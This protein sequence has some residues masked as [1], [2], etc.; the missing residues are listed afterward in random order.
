ML[1]FASTSSLIIKN[2]LHMYVINRFFI[3]SFVEILFKSSY[4]APFLNKTL[5]IKINPDLTNGL[6][7]IHPICLYTSIAL[8][9]W[10]YMTFSFV[11]FKSLFINTINY[12]YYDFTYKLFWLSLLLITSIF[13]GC[14]WAQ[15]ELSW[16][17]WWG[18]D[19]VEIVSLNY[20]TISV[21]LIHLG[22]KHY[23]IHLFTDFILKVLFF[24]AIV[25]FSYLDSIHN[26]ASLDIF[27]QNFYQL[28]FFYLIIF[29]SIIKAKT[30]TKIKYMTL[31]TFNT[32][33][34]LFV[35][36]NIFLYLYVMVEFIYIFYKN[37]GL[38]MY[39]IKNKYI[40]YLI[41]VIFGCIN[42]NQTK[43][44]ILNIFSIP[45]WE[46]SWVKFIMNVQ[47]RLNVYI[48]HTS[49]FILVYILQFNTLLYYDFFSTYDTTYD[50]IVNTICDSCY[51]Y[52][53]N[54]Q[55]LNFNKKLD[56]LFNERFILDK[57]ALVL[58]NNQQHVH[59]MSNLNRQPNTLLLNIAGF[60]SILV[61]LLMC[62]MKAALNKKKY[63]F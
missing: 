35:V 20:L 8:I 51:M 36:L 47:Y 7:L 14:W 24:T 1:F 42:Q 63:L 15:L 25:K 60:F 30:F 59:E 29:Y 62:I 55:L 22:S 57:N 28:A 31:N 38:N 53:D 50:T 40:F 11:K 5:E 17:G 37:T 41:L 23:L 4:S 48:L 19:F 13:L 6:L 10:I 33:L 9:L 2:G 45:F 32:L 39:I 34:I 58:S 26:F 16:G 44:W 52:L 43:L 49:V 46:L 61:F 3:L 18:W 54:T 56:V 12:A 21:L 27:L